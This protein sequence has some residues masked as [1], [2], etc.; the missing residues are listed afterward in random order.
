MS[1]LFKA[2]QKLEEQNAPEVP[3]PFS[4]SSG[5]K[6]SK[7]APPFLK[8]AL[9][10]VLLLLL[11]AVCLG[12]IWFAK[13]TFTDSPTVP[14]SRIDREKEHKIP[15]VE[16][17][18]VTPPATILPTITRLPE[19]EQ[20]VAQHSFPSAEKPPAPKKEI[21]DQYDAKVESTA[22]PH[23]QITPE[24][25]IQQV[26]PEQFID[27]SSSEAEKEQS[28][29]R[30]RKRIVYQA[31]KM[32]EQGDFSKALTL[33]KKVWSFGPHPDIAN[34]L[35]AILIQSKQ[36]KK[37]EGYLEQAISLAPDDEDL[38]F[39][40]NIARE[41]RKREKKNPFKSKKDLN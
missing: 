4:P 39:N 17:I 15:A 6:K 11:T 12:F 1:E 5:D 19:P 3:H 40:L 38:Q 8:S 37:A 7:K 26:S 18:S 9:L 31:E 24:S 41:G 23:K 27:G 29:E 34:N 32:R 35:A 16:P 13:N 30:Q 14:N 2:L 25:P 33:Y 36:Y 28:R 22:V 10:Y 21:T 20:V